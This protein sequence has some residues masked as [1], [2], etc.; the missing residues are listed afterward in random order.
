MTEEAVRELIIETLR[1][2]KHGTNDA[3][4]AVQLRAPGFDMPLA[5]LGM[6]SL[7]TIEWCMEVETRSGIEIDPGDLVAHSTMRALVGLLA[8]RGR[9]LQDSHDTPQL[10]RVSREAP[11]RLSFVQERT[12]K[13][14][15]DPRASAAFVLGM[16]DHIL[17]RLD[18]HLLRDSLSEIVKRHEILR[19]SFTVVH[20]QPAAIVHPAEPVALPVYRLAPGRDPEEELGRVFACEIAR[21]RD[22]AQPPLC[23]FALIRI[24]EDE[25]WLLR[26]CHHILWDAWSVDVL[27]GE[28]ARVY[29]ARHAGKDSPFPDNPSLQYAD[30]AAWQRQTLRRDGPAFRDLVSW[31]QQRLPHAS[32]AELPFQRALRVSGLA[33]A[34]GVIDCPVDGDLAKRFAQLARGEG[35]TPYVVW[36][37]AVVALLARETG[38]PD[39]LIGSYMT[40]RRLP[41]TQNMIGFFSALTALPF[42]VDEAMGFRV[43]IS[44][45]G[46]RAAEAEAHCDLAHQDLREELRR[47][48]IATPE[49]RMIFAAPLAQARSEQRFAGVM[50]RRPKLKLVSGMPW[51]FTL[52]LH[53]HDARPELRAT[54]DAARYDPAGVRRFMMHLLQLV[55]TIVRTPDLPLRDLLT[56]AGAHHTHDAS[57]QTVE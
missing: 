4:L 38:R 8:E 18:V 19:T 42:R 45:V 41:E 15:R 5:D 57:V 14:C 3:E 13:Y 48:G 52:E 40:N 26:A 20:G 36:L 25:H 35:A 43:W 32:S 55:E 27:L 12:W 30:Y 34:D 29:E 24:S 31:W 54:F 37:A 7:D 28:L 56:S 46:T 49:I 51:G 9:K 22:L 44:A 21:M 16:R 10:V 1:K 47:S 2:V 17:G 11:L 39:V 6:D 23:R 33:P 53:E 50:L